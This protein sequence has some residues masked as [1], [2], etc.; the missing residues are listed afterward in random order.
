MAPAT[1]GRAARPVV[2]SSASRRRPAE[3]RDTDRSSHGLREDAPIRPTDPEPVQPLDSYVTPA[4]LR[5]NRVPWRVSSARPA[6]LLLANNLLAGFQTLT[7]Q[8]LTPSEE[9]DNIHCVFCLGEDEDYASDRNEGTLDALIRPLPTP[10][11]DAE[12]YAVH[13]ASESS[14]T[15]G[16]R[17]SARLAGT[18]LPQ[19]PSFSALLRRS[20]RIRST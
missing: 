6:L 7:L 12:T 13:A 4:M 9:V 1:I 17:R 11:S 3:P 19:E 8:S 20:A 18:H 2:T 5:T 10:S 16:P 15:G 14:P